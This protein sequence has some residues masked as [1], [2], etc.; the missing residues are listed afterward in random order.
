VSESHELLDIRAERVDW[1]RLLPIVERALKRAQ[2]R[3]DYLMANS[4]GWVR[5]RIVEALTVEQTQGGKP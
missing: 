1:E 5:D 3:E 4:F 2:R